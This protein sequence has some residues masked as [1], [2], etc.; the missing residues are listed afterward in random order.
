MALME[1]DNAV[2]TQ[3]PS[4]SHN[5]LQCP[6]FAPEHNL[7][8]NLTPPSWLKQDNNPSENKTHAFQGCVDSQEKDTLKFPDD[9]ETK[10]PRRHAFVQATERVN[11]RGRLLFFK[12]MPQTFTTFLCQDADASGDGGAAW[13]LDE[14]A[15]RL[16]AEDSQETIRGK[17]LNPSL[18]CKNLHK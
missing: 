18:A 14:A 12:Y 16:L 6:G 8:I 4:E 15:Q 10:D 3:L 7:E 5:F 13:Q 1:C 9:G 11:G 2:A 17:F